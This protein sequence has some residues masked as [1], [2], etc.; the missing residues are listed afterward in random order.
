VESTTD[1][2]WQQLDPELREMTHSPGLFRTPVLRDKIECV[3]A[4]HGFR[5]TVDGLVQAT[6]QAAE[7]PAWF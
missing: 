1:V 6:R 5:K 3:V 7:E 4:Q 2:V